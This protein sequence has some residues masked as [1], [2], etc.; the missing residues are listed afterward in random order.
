MVT[1]GMPMLAF[2]LFVS[3]SAWG[4]VPPK[5][6]DGELE[7]LLEGHALERR[8]DGDLNGDG[9]SDIALVRTGE[10][11]RELVAAVTY[12]D[13]FSF[14]RDVV[15]KTELDAFAMGAATLKIVKGVLIVE[16]LTG[17]TSATSA[18]YRYRYEPGS[19]K[20]RLIGIDATYYSRTFSHDGLEFSWNLMTGDQVTHKLRLN[21]AGGDTAYLPSPQVRTKRPTKPIYME[22]TPDAGELVMSAAGIK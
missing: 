5:V 2:A 15:G 1:I 14:G 16:E 21:K 22:Q 11:L 3:S 7:A 10:D 13:E 19:K 18:T 9:K 20:M 12:S 6:T 8:V 4:Q 17:G